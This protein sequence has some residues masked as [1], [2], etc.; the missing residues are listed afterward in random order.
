MKQKKFFTFVALGFALTANAQKPFKDIAKDNEVE[1]L[2]LSNGRYIEHFINDTLRRIGSVMFNTV[3]NKIEYF[4]PQDDIT[5]RSE[6]DRT[7]EV[8]RWMSV[9]PLQAK[10]PN[11]SPYHSFANNPILVVDP[12]GK[13]NVIYIVMSPTAQA[14]L[15]VMKADAVLREAQINVDNIMGANKVKVQLFN[16][17]GFDVN[18]MDKSDAVAYIGSASEVRNFANSQNISGFEGFE[19]NAD[20]TGANPEHT[21]N[22]MIGLDAIGMDKTGA[23]VKSNDVAFTGALIIH[24]AGHTT[25]EMHHPDEVDVYG[26]VPFANTGFDNIM[27]SGNGMKDKIDAGKATFSDFTTSG[28]NKLLEKY[29]SKK[30]TADKPKDNY[31]NNKENKSKN[32]Y[33]PK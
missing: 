6:L 25:G 21:E 33:A 4:I 19:G 26:S 5:L 9:D 13:E 24:G 15:G 30:F 16:G 2:T 11:L 29:F 32:G 20:P 31:Q 10:Y 17:T 8:S 1:L 28:N 7:K 3:T 14:N 22:P 27:T 12:D 23:S 18:N